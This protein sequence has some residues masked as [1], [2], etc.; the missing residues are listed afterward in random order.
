MRV[1]NFNS[2]CLSFGLSLFRGHDVWVQ[3]AGCRWPVKRLGESSFCTHIRLVRSMRT[4]THPLAHMHSHRRIHV[5]FV[6]AVCR[7][8]S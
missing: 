6:V 7:W 4:A 5:C 1:A 3:G 2:I 8:V